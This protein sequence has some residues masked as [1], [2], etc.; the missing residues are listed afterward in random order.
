MV[1]L[2]VSPL[3]VF[4]SKARVRSFGRPFSPAANLRS[5]AAGSAET[6]SDR[7]TPASGTL[8]KD[9]PPRWSRRR[10]S[11]IILLLCCSLVIWVYWASILWRQSLFL[12]SLTHSLPHTI[13][14]HITSL[15]WLFRISRS[16]MHE[17]TIYSHIGSNTCHLPTRFTSMV[18]IQRQHHKQNTRTHSTPSPLTM[19]YQILYTDRIVCES[20]VR[21][22]HPMP[23]R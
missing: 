8:C 16:P 2:N 5:A 20:T 3:P 1:T 22:A 9:P 12:G 15:S 11:S 4:G 21:F 7:W 18:H 23:V 17:L 10:T 13:H 6:P 19:R 14:S